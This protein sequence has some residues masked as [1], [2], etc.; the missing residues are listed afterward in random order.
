[1]NP[2]IPHQTK[3]MNSEKGEH[4]IID[5]LSFFVHTKEKINKNAVI[6]HDLSNGYW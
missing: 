6:A 3:R 1:M 5:I 4:V 2:L